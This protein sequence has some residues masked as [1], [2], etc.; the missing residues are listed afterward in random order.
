M[1]FYGYRRPDGLIGIRNHVLILPTVGCA[2][3]TCRIIAGLV[4]GA[5]SFVNQGGCGEVEGNKKLTQDVL[6]GLAANPNVYGTI[7]VGLG[8]EPNCVGDMAE[9]IRAKTNKPL[10]SLV[11]QDEGGTV[12]TISKALKLAQEMVVAASACRQ[13][14]FPMTELMLGIECGGSDAT[15]GLIANPVM[16]CVSDRLVDLGG[17]TMFSETPEIIGA[18]HI[19]ARRGATPEVQQKILDICVKLEEDLRKV[20]Q[21]VRSGQPSPGNKAGGITTLEE[22]S[23]GCIHK[24]GTKPVME[25]VECAHRPSKKGLIYMDTPGYDML[26]VTAKV[27]A[28][29]QLIVF[30]TGRGNPIGNPIVPVLKVTA[31]HDLFRK[32]NDNMDMDFSAVLE[33]DKTMAEMGEQVLQE[34]VNITGGKKTKTEVFGF[35]YSE[36]VVRRMCDYI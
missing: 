21:S 11:I 8:C 32:M 30:T 7:L 26:S 27:A 16:G 33:G 2:N 17:T 23:L 25:V 28:G 10:Q 1:N 14:K 36:T 34:I 3:E 29:C 13:E 19:L 4:N 9:I 15:S 24:G 31:N 5:V 35:G 6:A 22:K 18:E 20:N 12:N